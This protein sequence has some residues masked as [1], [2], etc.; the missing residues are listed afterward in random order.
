[1]VHSKLFYL[2]AT[3]EIGKIIATGRDLW[4][5]IRVRVRLGVN[6]SVP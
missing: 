2:D 4:V 6:G 5:I 1:M 3:L